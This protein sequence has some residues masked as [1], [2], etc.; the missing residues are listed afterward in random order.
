[1][2]FLGLQL[3]LTIVSRFGTGIWDWGG[4]VKCEI[5]IALNEYCLDAMRN[6][7]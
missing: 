6:S 2:I 1:M 4:D 3:G 7:E 5:F